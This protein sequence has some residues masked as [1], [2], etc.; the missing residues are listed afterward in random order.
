MRG[1]FI[2]LAGE[3][4][5]YYAAGTRGAG[6]TLLLVHGFPT[7]GHLWSGVVPLLPSGHRVVVVD[8]LGFGRSDTP[9]RGDYTLAAHARRLTAL[10]DTLGIARAVLVGHHFGGAIAMALAAAEPSRVSRL[11]LL[12]PIGFDVSATG[13]FALIRAF[14][15]WSGLLPGTFLRRV[16]ARALERQYV[17]AERGRHSVDLY[18]RPFFPGRGRPRHFLEVLSGFSAA[19]TTATIERLRTAGIPC[20]VCAGAEDSLVPPH[21]ARRLATLL[22]EASLDMIEHVRHFAPEEAPERVAVFLARLLEA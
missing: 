11:G 13:T 8:L 18:L 20:G 5:Y 22:P 3:H 9:S 1:E 7:S 14:L 12:S 16:V 15:P 10:M 17:N 21:V 6:D 2:D 4:L 19:E